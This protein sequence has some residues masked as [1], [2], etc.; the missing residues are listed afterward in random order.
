[1]ISPRFLLIA[2]TAFVAGCSA[3]PRVAEPPSTAASA[4]ASESEREAVVLRLFREVLN[5]GRLNV[6]DELIAEGYV[7][8]NPLVP[9]GLDGFKDG[10][11]AFRTAFP[12]YSSSVEDIGIDGDRIWVRHTARGTFQAPYFGIEPTGR[13][14]EIAVADVF[15]I[16]TRPDGR[17]VLVEH[18][19]VFPFLDLLA[20]VAPEAAITQVR[21]TTPPSP[22]DPTAM[23]APENASLTA[24]VESFYAALGRSDYDAAFGLL[25]DDFVL[26]QAES[27]PYGGTWEGTDGVRAFFQRLSDT[28]AR[29]GSRETRYLTDGTTT[30]VALSVAEGETKAGEQFE[31]PMAQVYTVRGGK[32]V[33]ARPFYF[34]TAALNRAVGHDPQ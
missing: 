32:L 8:H 28:W 22:A 25:A 16:E 5:E 9:Q 19:D 26:A 10:L 31:M 4:V 30:V 33:E 18:W 15:R 3:T 17:S 6:A 12:D 13:P 29:F 23:A 27:L 14:F 11:A 21:T 34:D 2:V 7:Q 24:V 20:Q 1:M